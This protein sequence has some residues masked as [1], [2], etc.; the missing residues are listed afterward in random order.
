MTTRLNRQILAICAIFFTSFLGGCVSQSDSETDVTSDTNP[1]V[2]SPPVISGSPQ[3]A[4]TMGE[5]YS[6][7]P[8]ASDPDGDQL[9]FSVTNKP[10]WATFDGATGTLSGTPTLGNVGMYA[11]IQVT[12]SDGELDSSLPAFPIDVVE[13]ALG[14]VT[15]SWTPP[16]Q[17]VDGSTF[18]DL[19]AYRIY[20]GSE[21]GNYSRSVQVDN[22][23]V[24]SYVIDNLVPD[25]YYFVATSINSQGMESAHSNEAIKQVPQQ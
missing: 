21:S 18:S 3:N 23:G 19:I 4:V 7:T 1:V 12:V 9:T 22:P 5:S 10:S 2:N 20:F 6:F 15:L 25:T 24:A 17:N 13:V 8:T 14:S 16:T 11:D